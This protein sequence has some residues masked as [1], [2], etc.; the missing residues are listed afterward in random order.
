MKPSRRKFLA[1]TGSAAV[2]SVA[3]VGSASAA[4]PISNVPLPD[5]VSQMYPTMGTDAENPTATVFGNFKC[6]FTQDFV[7]N[8]LPDLAEKYVKTGKMNVRFRTISYE[9]YGRGK[10]HSTQSN[11]FISD[12]DPTISAT[13][14]GV[15]EEDPEAYWKYFETMFADPLIS[16]TVTPE[17]LKSVMNKSGVDNVKNIVAQ[18]NNGKY[19]S[20]VKDSHEASVDLKIQHT[21][22]FEIA[23]STF[24]GPKPDD[25][26]DL[27]NFV[28]A[29][30]S[31]A[32]TYLPKEDK[33]EDVK[34]G[35]GSGE[36][37]ASGETT[38]TF[39][40]SSA[41]GWANY[42]F[43]VSGKFKQT[44]TMKSSLED[45][46]SKDG[47]TA[48]GGVGPWEDT[49][50]YTGELTDLTLSQPIDVLRN[51]EPLDLEK[52]GA[53]IE[54]EKLDVKSASDTNETSESNAKN[55]ISGAC[56]R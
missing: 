38:I 40:G 10:T 53:N 29:N 2:T 4:I 1:V 9:P 7:N 42:E 22:T 30:L 51:E 48:S 11:A 5:N 18:V 37:S 27:L 50:T 31:G 49:Y 3:G 54:S 43:T 19:D 13:N 14:L 24:V 12:S 26:K 23:G 8:V 52:F 39:D 25:L 47:S 41:Q 46:D 32:E 17:K 55:S 28:Q 56:A 21:P 36:G 44:R 15:W 16:G 35:D 45:G 20:L 34:S 33:K 6:P